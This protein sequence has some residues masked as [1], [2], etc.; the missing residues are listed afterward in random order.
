[1]EVRA[2]TRGGAEF[3]LE[4]EDPEALFKELTSRGGGLTGWFEV[5]PKARGHKQAMIRSDEIVELRL[6]DEDE[7]SPGMRSLG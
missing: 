4:T 2:T 1:V 6:V 7:A 3:V 5:A